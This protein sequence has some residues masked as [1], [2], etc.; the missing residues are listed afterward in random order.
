MTTLALG[1]TSRASKPAISTRPSWKLFPVTRLLMTMIFLTIISVRIRIMRFSSEGATL[2]SSSHRT[3]WFS[4]LPVS[5]EH[6]F[7]MRPA[8]LKAIL[9]T[10]QL[11]SSLPARGRLM[12]PVTTRQTNR[13]T[14]TQ[15][16]CTQIS[17]TYHHE[18]ANGG[19]TQRGLYQQPQH[20]NQHQRQYPPQFIGPTTTPALHSSHCPSRGLLLYQRTRLSQVLNTLQ[21]ATIFR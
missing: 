10:L 2:H 8:L 14:S 16:T 18:P 1:L 12:A 6:S 5:P 9:A 11:F 21:R 15:S 13:H 19:R 4:H 20:H 17:P 7:H 3:M